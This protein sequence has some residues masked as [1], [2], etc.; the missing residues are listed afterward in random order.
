MQGKTGSAIIVGSDVA[1]TMLEMGHDCDVES[2]GFIFNRPGQPYSVSGPYSAWLHN[3][4]WHDY[5]V[6]RLFGNELVFHTHGGANGTNIGSIGAWR[7][8]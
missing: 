4:P 6:C 3:S 2:W 5:P 1:P 8:L 7:T